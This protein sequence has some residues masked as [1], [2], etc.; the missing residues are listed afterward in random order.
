MRVFDKKSL[1]V[2]V[3]LVEAKTAYVCVYVCLKEAS[4]VFVCFVEA[5]AACVGVFG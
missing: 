5:R 3:C 1:Y 2:C 4:T